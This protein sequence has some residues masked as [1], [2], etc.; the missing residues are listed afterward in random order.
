MVILGSSPIPLVEAAGGLDRV[1]AKAGEFPDALYTD[2]T[3]SALNDIPTIGEGE[4]NGT[5]QIAQEV[6]IAEQPDLV[7]GYETQAITRAGLTEAGIPMLI[8]PAFCTNPEQQPGNVSFDDV[9][10]QVEFYGR[11]FGAEKQ[12]AA[13]VANLR[14][15]VATVKKSAGSSTDRTAATL[16]VSLGGGP[17]YAYGRKSTAIPRWKQSA[18]PT[19]SATS[20]SGTST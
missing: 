2:K 16:F 3:R 19:C 11:V 9:Y 6:V 14:D 8:L 15:R 17:I 5:M 7:I 4:N 13:A 10:E 18:S 12:A 1:V 20:T